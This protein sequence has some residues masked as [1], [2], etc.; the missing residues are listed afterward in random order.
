MDMSL[1]INGDFNTD[2]FGRP[3]EIDGTDEILQKIYISLSGRRGKFIYDRELGGELY[4]TELTDGYAEELLEA[5]AREAVQDIA[6]AEICGVRIRHS[7]AYAYAEI[8][9]KMYEIEL[10]RG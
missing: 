3:Y 10:R 6:G 9:G 7:V 8:D 5:A 2:G 1:N 4:K